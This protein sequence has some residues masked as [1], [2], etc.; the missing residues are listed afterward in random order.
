MQRP[1][2][3]RKNG[4]LS[5]GPQCDRLIVL[6]LSVLGALLPTASLARSA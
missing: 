4:V 6:L 3:A 2:L 5:R 1:V